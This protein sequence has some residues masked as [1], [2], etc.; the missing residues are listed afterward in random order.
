MGQSEGQSIGSSNGRTCVGCWTL[1]LRRGR[2]ETLRDLRL[3][4]RVLG[5][6]A[7]GDALGQ[8]QRV[9]ALGQGHIR[10]RGDVLAGV[11]VRKVALAARLD[12]PAPALEHPRHAHAV[13][14]RRVAAAV[15]GIA[16]LQPLPG[17]V[18][19]LAQDIAGRVAACD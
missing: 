15:V 2:E 17:G 8:P 18:G 14:R 10:H 7:A 5:Q 1:K 3:I 19:R 4:I 9:G 12:A 16:T 6:Q 13:R 11:D